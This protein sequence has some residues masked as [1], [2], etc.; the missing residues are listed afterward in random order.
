MAF[1][2]IALI[3]L[4][5]LFVKQ[6]HQKVDTC[7]G[8][9]FLQVDDVWLEGGYHLGD[10]LKL[11]AAGAVESIFGNRDSLTRCGEDFAIKGHNAD[12]SFPMGR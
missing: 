4:E 5:P 7:L 1:G 8:G 11:G 10:A 6:L 3:F 12:A 9:D 2:M